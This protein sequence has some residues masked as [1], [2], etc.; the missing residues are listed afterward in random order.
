M[1]VGHDNKGRPQAAGKIAP[2]AA[3]LAAGLVA[4]LSRLPALG[5]WW[6]QDD[7]GLLARAAGLIDDPGAPARWLSRDLYWQAMWPLAGLAPAPYAVTRILLHALAAAGTARLAARLGLTPLQQWAAGLIMAASPLAFGPL[8]W[9]AGVQDLLAVCCLVWALERWRRGGA[10]G[11]GMAVALAAAALA[12][13]EVVVGLPVLLLMLGAG[14]APESR[15]PGLWP[16]VAAGLV[17]VAAAAALAAAL[18]VFGTGDGQPYALGSAASSL[19]R[20]LVYGWWLMLPG[21]VFH[22]QPH[23]LMA[24]AG[25]LLWL[26]WAAWALVSWR[27]GGRVPA[28]TLAGA[29]LML[30]PVLPLARHLSPDLAYPVEPFGCLALAALVPARWRPRGAALAM[31][32]AAALAWGYG[33]MQ[34]RLHL[35]GDDGLHADPVVRRT[36][37]SWQACRE[38]RNLPAPAD[39][40]VMLQPPLTR[41][42]AVMAADLGEGW[43]TG[44][45]LY[46][47]LEGGLGPRLILGDDVP[48]VW[49]NGLRL[50][51]RDALVLLDAGARFKP[52]GPTRQA[53]LNQVLTDVGSGLFDRARLHLLRAS[54]LAGDSLALVFDPD[55]LPV[56]MSGVLANADPFLDHLAAGAARGRSPQEI[57]GLQQN[58]RS[59]L[60]A[61]TGQAPPSSDDDRTV[62]PR[63]A[64]TPEQP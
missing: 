50:T 22:P 47:A 18:D 36:A 41:T 34:A 26:A 5:A 28:L 8:Y 37:V 42:T 13:K 56:P 2:G 10:A 48:V 21:P 54:L 14:S 15:R 52:W 3:A 9:A 51:P 1:T 27:R 30:L 60:A 39:G 45:T 29:L 17:A 40:L 58:F 24:A 53:L 55:V 49:T 35:R 43:V 61:C 11:L 44:S 19:G 64:P 7:W 25:G 16:A 57:A 20:L 23:G 31:M 32:T 33:G 62:G 4:V 12:A 63:P 6:N 38:L 59:L 46:H